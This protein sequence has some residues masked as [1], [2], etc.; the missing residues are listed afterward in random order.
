MID[1]QILSSIH[2]I[3][4]SYRWKIG[5]KQIKSTHEKSSQKCIFRAPLLRLQT[6]ITVLKM[7]QKVFLDLYYYWSSYSLVYLIYCLTCF[8]FINPFDSQF[9]NFV[10]RQT[11][12]TSRMKLLRIKIKK[13]GKKIFSGPS[14]NF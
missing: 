13:K 7:H 1:R 5:V 4:P 6:L 11:P 3:N 2:L 12:L 9:G 8:I 14:K 10:L